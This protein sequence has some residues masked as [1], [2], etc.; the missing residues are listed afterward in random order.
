MYP[1]D[2]AIILC[3]NYRLQ[4]PVFWF[5][6]LRYYSVDRTQEYNQRRRLSDKVTTLYNGVQNDAAGI[7]HNLKT[8]HVYWAE[9]VPEDDSCILG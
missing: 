3:D 5:V 6:L 9:H 2:R 8:I 1:D 7:E 4:F